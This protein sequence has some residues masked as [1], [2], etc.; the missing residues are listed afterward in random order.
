[1]TGGTK[2]LGRAR[3]VKKGHSWFVVR[4]CWEKIPLKCWEKGAR[5]T[6]ARLPL[7]GGVHF[8]RANVCPAVVFRDD[9]RV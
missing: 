2:S 1:M 9:R 8:A 3:V 7:S 4:I 6:H 5:I